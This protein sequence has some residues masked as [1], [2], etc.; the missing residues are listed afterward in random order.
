[1]SSEVESRAPIVADGLAYWEKQPAT[2]D[3]VLGGY[4]NGSLP[5]IE[6]LG[7]RQFLLHV[8]PDL[9]T[10]PSALRPLKPSPKPRRIRALDVGA[11][12]GRVTADTLLHL[13]DDVVLVEPVDKLL[14]VARQRAPG[15]KGVE[16]GAKSVTVMRGTLQQ[17]DPAHPTES[18]EKLERFG[19]TSEEDDMDSGFDVVWGQWCLMYMSDADLIDFFVRCKKALRDEKSVIVVKENIGLDGVGKDG[20]PVPWVY[21]DEED[22]SVAR[23]DLAFKELFQKA[24][25]KLV[26]EQEQQGLPQELYGVKMYALR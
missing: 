13:V 21:F 5:R 4:G 11:G 3:G 9:C 25:L 26:H 1:M 17:F 15:I 24:G 8:R 19:Y 10:V 6:T 20:K 14:D 22:S 12:V 18:A 23:S 16:S 2:V 7:S